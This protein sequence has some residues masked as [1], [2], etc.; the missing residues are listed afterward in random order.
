MTTTETRRPRFCTVCGGNLEICQ[1]EERE[2]PVC[3]Q[4]GRVQ[5]G[6]LIV[7]AGCLIE[8]RQRLLLIRRRN[9][10][11]K[12]AWCLPAGHVDDDE[13]PSLAAEREATE[14]TGLQVEIGSLVNAYFSDDHPAGCGVFLVY[15]GTVRGGR[16]QETAEG[17]TPTF[18]GRDEIPANLSGGGHRTA[19]EAWR[20]RVTEPVSSPI[21]L[22]TQLSIVWT[23]RY[24][25]DQVLWRVFAAFWPTN[26]ILLAALFRSAG[27]TLP[28]KMGAIT[29]LCGVF[30]AIVWF[31][32]QRRALGHVKRIEAIA[33]E[34]EEILLAPAHSAYA[35][36]PNLSGSGKERIGGV[37]ARTLMPLCTAA[38][39][40][41]WLLG[42]IHFVHQLGTGYFINLLVSLRR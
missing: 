36:S 4:C 25:Q 14:E 37:A 26:A 41:L 5:Y 17:S 13:A 35:L 28:P 1:I 27:Q 11:F 8:D 7:G 31:L 30:I 16:L 19:I 32:I 18:F 12:D 3:V 39:L 15:R 24:Q 6:Q 21:N 34:I 23:A 10:P 33:E 29:A 2:R 38:V 20:N 42:L 22:H 9:E 40:V